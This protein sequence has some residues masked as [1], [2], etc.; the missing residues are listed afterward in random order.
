MEYGSAASVRNLLGLL[1]FAGVSLTIGC[2]AGSDSGSKVQSPP[3][4]LSSI[5]V[6]TAATSPLIVGGT[7]Q[8]TAA[9]IY[10]DGSAKDVSSIV[11]WTSSSP[12]IATVSSAGLATAVSAGT[13]TITASLSG[14]TGTAGLTVNAEKALTAIAVRPQGLTVFLGSTQQFEAI[15]SYNDGSTGD[16]TGSVNWSSSAPS[17]ASISSTGLASALAAGPATITASSA[18]ISGSSTLAV[19][20]SDSG[21]TL[22]DDITDSRLISFRDKDA[23]VVQYNGTR[24]ANG[25]LSTITSAYLTHPNGRS[26]TVLFDQQGLPVDFQMSDG[27]E[28]AILWPSNRS[29]ATVTAFSSDHTFVFSAPFSSPA[30]TN[31]ARAAAAASD[32]SLVTVNVRSYGDQKENDAN[33]EVKESG[34]FLGGSIP[35][36]LNG[37]GT[38]EA[39]LPTGSSIPSL[40]TLDDLVQSTVQPFQSTCESLDNVENTSTTVGVPYTALDTKMCVAL[41]AA[42]DG[43]FP[44]AIPESTALYT[45]CVS[46][47]AGLV[48]LDNV[49]AITGDASKASQY[50]SAADTAVI[51]FF[52][53]VPVDVTATAVLNLDSESKT[54]KKQPAAGPFDQFNISVGAV[55]IDKVQ[56]TPS[57]LTLAIDASDSLTAG[58]Y[59][60]NSQLLRS[61]TFKWNWASDD[62]NVATVP[63]TGIAVPGGEIQ[64]VGLA[65]VTAKANPGTSNITATET[66]SNQHSSAHVT[67]SGNT[68]ACPPNI[69]STLP[70]TS[71][72]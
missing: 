40:Q 17:S 47:G 16:V 27:S 43:A 10:S 54:N 9:A 24:N 8:F 66:V 32:P 15:G 37:A 58:A 53:A 72:K 42:L 28:F 22:V 11:A 3:V 68:C 38:Y 34:T 30:A 61:S 55:P 7:V 64:S 35:A 71:W 5:S 70:K 52:D 25:G 45:A 56:V 69:S 13:D 44:V 57:S 4:T 18:G 39:H 48:V 21:F 50:L 63:A 60:S 65:T 26:Q 14:V 31:A 19:S 46:L 51:N 67:V 49:C 62:E 23:S 59:N 12:S 36:E 33:V 6:S 20:S 2:G 29:P 41:T 1:L